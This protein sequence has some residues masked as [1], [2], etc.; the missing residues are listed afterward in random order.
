METDPGVV[1]GF[2]LKY[3]GFIQGLFNVTN[4]KQSRSSRGMKYNIGGKSCDRT[5]VLDTPAIG[6]LVGTPCNP[7]RIFVFIVKHR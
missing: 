4:D 1:L 5:E 6:W 2:T 7:V 3:T